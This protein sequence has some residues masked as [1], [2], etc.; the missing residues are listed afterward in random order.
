[1]D[2]NVIKKHINSIIAQLKQ[3]GLYQKDVK[4]FKFSSY[5]GQES[6]YIRFA[7]IRSWL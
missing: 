2:M 5:I 4:R 3:Y 6:V 1:M 7:A